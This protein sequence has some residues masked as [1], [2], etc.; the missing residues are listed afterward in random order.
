MYHLNVIQHGNF[1][2]FFSHIFVFVE[3]ITSC[4]N[5]RLLAAAPRDVAELR[6]RLE[7]RAAE[8]AAAAE[9]RLAER[10]AREGRDLRD[11]L[12]RQRERVVAELT[13]R[14]AE[15]EQTALAFARDE[16]R[17]IEADMRHWRR[18]LDRFERDLER[19]PAR[20]REFYEVRARR[21]EPVGLVYLWPETN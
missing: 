2:V 11:T 5:Y 15:F 17:Q 9:R 16:T 7:P 20:V 14:E 6:P 18:R 13:R 10:G 12:R 3:V 19:E 4:E 21:V 8:F 1:S